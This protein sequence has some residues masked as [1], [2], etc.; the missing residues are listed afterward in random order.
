MNESE[1]KV[2]TI[3]IHMYCRSKHGK[4]DALCYDCNE[5][6]TYAL[7]R[8]E[9]C[10]YGED[11]P[12]CNTCPIHCYKSDMRARIKKVMRF[13]GPRMLFVHP[14]ATLRHFQ[15]EYKRKRLF[16]RKEQR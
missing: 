7:S 10:P 6:R 12:T 8:L 1:K 14:I 11:K 13:S 4:K 5:L 2:V 9:H 16:N 15:K 3:M